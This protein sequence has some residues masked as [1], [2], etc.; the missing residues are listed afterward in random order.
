M[1]KTLLKMLVSDFCVSSE[2]AKKRRTVIHQ[3]KL[4]MLK[5]FKDSL[6]RRIASISASISIL[7]EQI[8]RDTLEDT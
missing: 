2:N 5:F 8:K 3:R 1:Q 4:E 6:E 7:E